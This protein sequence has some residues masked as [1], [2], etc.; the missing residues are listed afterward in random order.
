MDS[1]YQLLDIADDILVMY[2]QAP[3]NLTSAK[4]LVDR[5]TIWSMAF[6]PGVTTA[7]DQ[8]QPPISV[9]ETTLARLQVMCSYY[10]SLMF[11]TRP[12]LC[13]E[14]LKKYAETRDTPVPDS[15]AGGISIS[16][17]AFEPDLA[18][19]TKSCEDAAVFMIGAC[20]DAL[21]EGVL[22]DNMP[23][24]QSVQSQSCTH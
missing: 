19:L 14:S 13:I 16:A 15:D 18:L 24:L 6:S 11:T 3:S 20:H 2:S 21:E 22:L 9:Q 10:Y 17:M 8:N 23:L 7:S 5:L 12:F 1:T 4:A